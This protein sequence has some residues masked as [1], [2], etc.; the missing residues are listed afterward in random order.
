MVADREQK[1]VVP[2]CRGRLSA[3]SSFRL[4]PNDPLRA[5]AALTAFGKVYLRGVN[6]KKDPY[7]PHHA[8][9]ALEQ[10]GQ[11]LWVTFASECTLT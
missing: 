7:F 10:S 11:I 9:I 6:R 8:E 4:R 2:V 1:A 5:S 3:T